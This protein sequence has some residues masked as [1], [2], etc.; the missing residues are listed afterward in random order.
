MERRQLLKAF[1]ALGIAQATSCATAGD[2]SAETGRDV[3]GP[4]YPV[5]PIPVDRS[6]IVDDA[7]AGEELLLDGQVRNL[8]GEPLQDILVEIWQ[9]DGNSI[10]QHPKA[11][12][13]SNR[14]PH[15]RGF[16]AQVTDNTG[17]YQFRTIVPVPY[18]GRPPHIHAK[19]WLRDKEMLITQ[20]YLDGHRGANNRKLKPQPISDNETE[21]RLQY[22]AEFDFIL[23]V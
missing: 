16:A 9:C 17:A 1:T 13:L 10:Y 3:E 11:P 8:Q 7:F 14:D 15:F 4:Y 23:A 12:D 2:E 21:A 19:L 18:P 22:Q 6:L 20:I 5:V